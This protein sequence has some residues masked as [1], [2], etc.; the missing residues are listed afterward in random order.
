[1]M[2]HKIVVLGQD[3]LSMVQATVKAYTQRDQDAARFIWAQDC[4]IDR[5][6]TR[7]RDAI[8]EQLEGTAAQKLLAQD[9]HEV[10]L[11]TFLLG[12]TYRLERI[13]DHCTNICERIVFLIEGNVDMAPLLNE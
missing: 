9:G 7:V 4:Q 11:L 13:A 3:V 12:I 10:Q 8:L 5:S 6:A 1:A 2:R